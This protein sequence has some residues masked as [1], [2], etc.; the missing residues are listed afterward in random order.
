M[1]DL[2]CATYTTAHGNARF[3]THWA[4]PEIKPASSWI[5]V[6]FV[7][8][9]PW[10]ECP[11]FLFFKKK[12]IY[13]FIFLFRGEPVA[14]GGSQARGLHHS[15]SNSGLEPSLW[16]TPQLMAEWGQGQN[17]YPHDTS[18]VRYC[19]AAIG[20]PPV[21]YFFLRIALAIQAFLWFRTHFRIVCSISVKNSIGILIGIVS[22]L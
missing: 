16:P 10:Q 3:L 6:S 21:L 17:P 18:W 7:T 8:T 1:Q 11:Y 12:F 13:L 4:R 5:Q 14:Y 2:S 20:T 19:W 9:E 22:N 15:Y